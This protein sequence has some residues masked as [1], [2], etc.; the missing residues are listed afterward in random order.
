MEKDTGIQGPN[1]DRI[2]VDCP[3]LAPGEKVITDRDSPNIVGGV[4]QV[5]VTDR[6]GYR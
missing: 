5:P 6:S 4:Y 2:I 3:Q 1:N